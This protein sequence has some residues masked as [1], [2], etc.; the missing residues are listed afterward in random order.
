MTT[1]EQYLV[2]LER[3]IRQMCRA[4]KEGYKATPTERHRLE[5]FIQAGV[6]MNLTTNAD[7]RSLLEQIYQ[8]VFDRPMASD[9]EAP[10]WDAPTPDY[11][12]Y[13]KPTYLR[14]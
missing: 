13:D 10:R 2:E 5:G 8:E 11:E 9:T 12:L 14:K 1:S 6:F 7:T 4:S 3:R